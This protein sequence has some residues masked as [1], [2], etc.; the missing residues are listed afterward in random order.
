M[1]GASLIA[2]QPQQIRAV[3]WYGHYSIITSAYAMLNLCFHS[4]APLA[5]AARRRRRRRRR[6]HHRQRRRWRQHVRL[7]NMRRHNRLRFH[8]INVLHV[9]GI[10][11]TRIIAAAGIG[12]CCRYG[13]RHRGQV[14]HL[15][16]AEVGLIAGRF[17]VHA[18][19]MAAQIDLALERLV[20]E[21]ALERLVARVFAHVR[22]QV[23][24]L[25]K[26]LLANDACV[27]FFA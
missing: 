5:A 3:I 27:R 15:A 12:H 25:A 19:A 13:S 24:T 21:F 4:L 6:R 23:G 22:N 11:T 2:S 20:A 7:Q 17:R 16:G 1:L 9:I 10:I 18:V 14:Q 8:H 26:G